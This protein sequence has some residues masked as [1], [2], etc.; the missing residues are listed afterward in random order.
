M[1]FKYT[2]DW[3]SENRIPNWKKY[4]P[5]V[6]PAGPIHAVEIGTFEARA[7]VWLLQN[8]LTHPESTLWCIDPYAYAGCRQ[9]ILPKKL[10]AAKRLAAHNLKQFGGKA[11]LAMARSENVLPELSRDSF[12]LIRVD[13]EHTLGSTLADM[14]LSWLLLKPGGVLI[15]DDYDTDAV[16]KH[17]TEWGIN[18][19]QSAV[20][21]FLEFVPA[22]KKLWVE[23]DVGLQKV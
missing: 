1:N 8:I 17:V 11:R 19:P 6:L 5:A 14:V 2:V 22:A 18:S 16:C 7:A 3:I 13:G 10:A 4:L 23:Y 20:N 9:E 21:V 15:V 12:D